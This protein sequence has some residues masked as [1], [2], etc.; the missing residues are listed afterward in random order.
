MNGWYTAENAGG[1]NSNNA[2]VRN[3]IPDE[4]MYPYSHPTELVTISNLVGT[5]DDAS[6]PKHNYQPNVNSR[7]LLSPQTEYDSVSY[8]KINFTRFATEENADFLRIYDGEDETA[9]LLGEFSGT[10]IPG[11]VTSTNNKVLLVFTT[12]D[13]NEDNGW[14]ISYKAY[15]PTWCSGLTNFTE[16]TGTFDDGS[17]SFYYNNGTTCMWTIQPK[18]ANK[19][20]ISFNYFDTEDGKDLLKVYDLQSQQLLASLSGNTIPDPITSNSGKFYLVWTT[21]NVNR[22]LG[23]EINYEAD[24]VGINENDDVFNN[25]SIYPN[26]ADDLLNI[27][28]ISKESDYVNISLINMTGI[29]VYKNVAHAKSTVFTNSIDLSD[30]AKGVYV[31]RLQSERKDLIRKIVVE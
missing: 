10:E 20:T 1:F 17:G 21:N 18:W 16:P 27:S 28:F 9:P 7:W 29:E 12:D 5:L 24:N 25:L 15:Q 11:E 14:L 13:T 23:W 2:I 4:S 30:L 8:I 31:L 19:T 22:G 6:G 3:F 26:P